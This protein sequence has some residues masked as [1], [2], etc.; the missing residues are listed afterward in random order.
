MKTGGMLIAAMALLAMAR[1]A[2]AQSPAQRLAAAPDGSVRFSFAARPGVCG[3]GRNITTE[4][5]D[6]DWESDC[7]DGP[8]R[9]V[10]TVRSRRVT[11]VRTYVGGRW[12][13]GAGAGPA[14]DWG[15]LPARTAADFLVTLARTAD[16][17]AGAK[18]I[19]PVTLADSVEPWGGLLAIARDPSVR[20]ETRKQS[21]FWLGQAAS[22]LAA[23]GLDSL[24]A[25]RD[26]DRTIQEQVVFAL[27]QR[28]KDE[29]IPA[30]VRVART[31]P[32]AEIRKKAIFWLGQSDDPRAIAL[33]EELLLK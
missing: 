30:L 23:R 21:V 7:D 31:H 1:P 5:N 19:F 33:F 3:N 15:T 11:G 10:L 18:A 8:V 12:R 9:V 29:G 6:R 24:L 16:S 27:S 32:D 2:G 28:P 25:D 13:T 22:N 26:G 20:R 17:D 4:R 14:T